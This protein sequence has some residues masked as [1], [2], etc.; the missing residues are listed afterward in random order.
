MMTTLAFNGLIDKFSN[1]VWIWSL[2]EGLYGNPHKERK[3][4]YSEA[5]YFTQR[6]CG[7]LKLYT[8]SLKTWKK[9]KHWRSEGLQLYRKETPTQLFSCEYCEIFKNSL[10]I[11]KTYV[12]A[13]VTTFAVSSMFL[14][15]FRVPGA[16]Q[17]V[18]V[19]LWSK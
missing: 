5:V 13:L 10:L 17:P 12:A 18:L 4:L 8:A 1:I 15:Y 11:E 14:I 19:F 6:E 7:T 9:L 2:L 3:G 16:E